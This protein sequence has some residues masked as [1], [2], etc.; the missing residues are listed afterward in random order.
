M[1]IEITELQ[2]NELLE[3]FIQHPE[4]YNPKEFASVR[5][6]IIENYYDDYEILGKISSS[7]KTRSLLSSS[8]L[9]NKIIKAVEEQRFEFRSDEIITDIF[10]ILEQVEKHEDRFITAEVRTASLG[11]LTYVFGLVDKQVANTGKT[12]DFVK[13]LNVLFCFFK[14]VVDGL[15]IEQVEQTRYQ[16]MFKKVQQMFLFSNNKN[17]STW[18]KFYFHF[19]DKKLSNNN[20]ETGIKTTIATYFKVTNNAKV[21]KDNIEEIKPVEEF[22]ALEANYENE[23]YS[24]A[25]SDTKY[26]NEFYEFFN[27]GKKQSL[28]ESWIPKSADEFKEVLKSS[29]SDIPNKLKLGNRILQKTKTLSNINEREGFYD[30]FFVLDLSKDEISQTDFSGQIINIV[31]STDV[32]LHQLGIKQYLENGKYVVTQDLK[33]K[34]V[35]FLFSIITNLNAYHKQFENILNLKIGI[36]KRQFDKEI[37]DTSNSVEYISNYLIQSGNYNFY[38]TVISKLLDYTIS[39]INERFITNINNQPKYLEMLKHIDN[40]SNK[41]KLPENVLDKLKSLISSGV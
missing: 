29:D 39:I 13:E 20:L 37:C 6:V 17:A 23:I 33:N 25:K 19:H 24:R 41:N 2:K 38:T 9:W 14:K 22:I 11:F 18:F 35:P 30:S 7:N 21:L 8:S 1:A 16:G 5:A 31:C 34:A 28:L 26:F 12:N 36:Y 27:D 15:K 32:N 3:N 4:F 10:F 40:Q